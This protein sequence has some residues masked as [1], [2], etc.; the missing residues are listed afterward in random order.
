VTSR[1]RGGGDNGCVSTPNQAPTPTPNPSQST[2]A[3]TAAVPDRQVP[4]PCLS[5]NGYAEC[6]A[7]LHRGDARA[8][9]AEMLMR[10]RYAAFAVGDADY[11]LRTWHPLT[12][13]A[14]LALDADVR[15][16]RLDIERTVRG[17]PLDVEGIVEFTAYYR[18]AG[19]RG[20]GDRGRQHEV[21]R[22]EK[23]SG[24]WT[25]VDAVD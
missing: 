13:P 25:Y 12:R 11:L 20:A 5:G 7:R 3:P 8:A 6:C 15:W 1:T 23:V 22:F 21:S 14:T 9:T 18:A 4:C 19:P 2:G 24:A 10:S 17:G 16:V